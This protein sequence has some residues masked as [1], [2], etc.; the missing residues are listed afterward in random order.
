MNQNPSEPRS[1]ANAS[2]SAR[3]IFSLTLSNSSS[4]KFAKNGAISACA[5]SSFS[6]FCVATSKRL[7]LS[8][9]SP[10]SRILTALSLPT[11][12]ISMISPR[13]LTS[14]MLST[15]SR[16]SYPRRKISSFS[17]LKFNSSPNFKFSGRR[18]LA[19]GSLFRIVRT[20][21]IK[22]FLPFSL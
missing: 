15:I 1:R 9:V 21:E 19:A 10:S 3:D 13:K 14:P 20:G 11:E 7:M 6:L 8:T 22:I 16:T 4:L 2:L 18:W 17:S 5:S 12:K